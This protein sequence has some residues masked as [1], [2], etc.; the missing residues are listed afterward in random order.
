MARHLTVLGLFAL[1]LSACSA[2]ANNGTVSSSRNAAMVITSSQLT[3][4]P[5]LLGALRGRLGGATIQESSAGCPRITLRGTRSM[6]G[7]NDPV[8]YVDGVRATNTCILHSMPTANLDR[9]EIYSS[10]VAPQPPYKAHPNGLILVFS[11]GL[12]FDRH[13]EGEWIRGH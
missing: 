13:D 10:G 1:S 6:F 12:T 9:V 11:Q 8:V 3:T 2:A 5:N 4:N 7:S